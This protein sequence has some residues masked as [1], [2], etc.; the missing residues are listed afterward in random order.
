MADIGFRLLQRRHV[1]KH[2]RLAQL[3][4]RSK[5]TDRTG[6]GR[7]YGCRLAGPDILAPGTRSDINGVLDRCGQAA[8]VFRRD[9]QH[10]IDAANLIPETGPSSRRR[11]GFQIRVVEGRSPI[12]TISDCIPWGAS[13]IRARAMARFRTPCAGCQR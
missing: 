10:R 6:R 3:M 2:Q 1:H 7:D 11:I 5:A 8:I 9:K 4:V 13:L 12:S